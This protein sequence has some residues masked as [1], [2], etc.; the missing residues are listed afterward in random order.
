[1]SVGDGGRQPR[2]RLRA[3]GVPRCWPRSPRTRAWGAP[4]MAATSSG[5]GHRARRAGYGRRHSRAALL[6]S[7][8]VIH[9]P[10][11]WPRPPR[12]T[13]WLRPPSHTLA[14]RCWPWRVCSPPRRQVM[15][16]KKRNK[17]CGSERSAEEGSGR[18]RQAPLQPQ[19]AK[20]WRDP[21][22]TKRSR[23]RPLRR[24]ER[25]LGRRRLA[26]RARSV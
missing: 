22:K 11:C 8:A 9:A 14:S 20:R 16:K 19:R 7:A 2:R 21:A 15:E 13:R 12:A 6:A 25:R 18:S 3:T 23:I 24:R 5:L 26:L 1:M 17:N 4:A 10:R